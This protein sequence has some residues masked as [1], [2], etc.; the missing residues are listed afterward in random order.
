MDR[1]TKDLDKIKGDILN[2]K[3]NNLTQNDNIQK[4]ISLLENKIKKLEKCRKHLFT[5]VNEIIKLKV[6][7]GATMAIVTMVGGGGSGGIGIVKEMK[8][9][10]G[11][12]GGAGACFINK[13]IQVKCKNIILIRVG[14]GGNI[15]TGKHGESSWIKIVDGCNIGNKIKVNGG[16][17]GSPNYCMIVDNHIVNSGGSGGHSCVPCFSG[18]SGHDGQIS[19]PSQLSVHGGSGGCSHFYSGGEGGSNF[20]SCGGKGGK[21]PHNYSGED[22]QQGSGG[23]GSIPRINVDSDHKLSGNGGNGFVMIEFS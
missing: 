4:N 12:G 8:Y 20:F 17:N 11:G 19:F 10:S 3:I 21:Y 15:V 5:N 13:P 1:V 22:G 14:K 2:I 18:T 6:P 16:K 9:Y 7:K 23:G